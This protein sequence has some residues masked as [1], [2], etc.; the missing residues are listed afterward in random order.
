MISITYKS[1]ILRAPAEN[2][3]SQICESKNIDFPQTTDIE[4]IWGCRLL[5]P[6][7]NLW[8]SVLHFPAAL[9]HQRLREN[10]GNLSV[11]I[12]NCLSWR[13][14]QSEQQHQQHQLPAGLQKCHKP[15][16]PASCCFKTP[17]YRSQKHSTIYI[18]WLFSAEY[19]W[20]CDICSMLRCQVL[21]LHQRS[22]IF[23]F[24]VLSGQR[25]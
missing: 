5:A 19:Q 16:A 4:W 8:S 3:W 1:L 13:R 12:E 21:H 15:E 20:W 23:R 25:Q 11:R 24:T 22:F 9:H 14:S 2:H 18:N 6:A 7:L 17:N 10:L